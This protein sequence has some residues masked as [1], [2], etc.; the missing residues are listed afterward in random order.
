MSTYN[1][2][3][4]L[5][6]S[7]ESILSQTYS[8]FELV[9]VNNGS[10]DGSEEICKH[11]AKYD[12]RIKLVEIQDNNGAPA[13]RN[14]GLENAQYEYVTIV[15][16]DDVCEPEMLEFLWNL[17]SKYKAD[18]SI[19]GSWNKTGDNLEPY[20][21]YDDL[22]LLNKEEGLEE[23][24]KREKYNVAPP[25]KLFR[26]SLFDNIRFKAGVLVDDIHV[27]YK[28]FANANRVV[29][30]GKPLYYFRKHS[31]NMT[32]FIQTNNLTPQLLQEYLNAFTERTMYLSKKVPQVT[33]RAKY[34][35]WSY[36][37]SMCKK[38]KEYKILS[39]ELI[40][41]E[42]VK[43]LLKNYTSF[44]DNPYITNEE[45]KELKRLRTNH[46]DM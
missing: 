12:K 30:Q 1:R 43:K 27:I 32:S 36:M 10:T 39:C 18:I 44:L 37:L 5:P 46:E 17:T 34:S 3:D 11:Y 21:I 4:Y 42:M 13:G 8:G 6:K 33:S 15:D 2:N 16:D 38:I 41:Q 29:A 22:L 24:L 26:K 31:N 23:L 25:T 45:C 9:L 35:E 14:M 40:Y 20:F 19:C 28:V 7:I